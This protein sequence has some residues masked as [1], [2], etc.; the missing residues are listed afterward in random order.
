MF[1]AGDVLC[2]KGRQSEREAEFWLV[3]EGNTLVLKPLSVCE[4]VGSLLPAHTS[5][6]TKLP[7][8]KDL[9]VEDCG[10]V[11]SNEKEAKEAARAPTAAP[12]ARVSPCVG[13]LPAAPSARVS[14][15]VHAKN[16]NEGY[17]KP[18]RGAVSY[19]ALDDIS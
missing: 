11:L 1:P 8:L 9:R 18:R 5:L 19:D 15:S 7:S 2:V 4:V 10:G 6:L 12:S 17:R 3:T 16:G 14:P 13:S